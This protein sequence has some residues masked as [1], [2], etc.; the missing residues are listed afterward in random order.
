M[1]DDPR[2]LERRNEALRAFVQEHGITATHVAERQYFDAGWD[3]GK[4]E[5]ADFI[6]KLTNHEHDLS[7]TADGWWVCN[8]CPYQTKSNLT[9]RAGRA[10]EQLEQLAEQNDGLA[11][12]IKLGGN[13]QRRLEGELEQLREA[14]KKS[15]AR[16]NEIKGTD[17][18]ITQAAILSNVRMV[19]EAALQHSAPSSPTQ[20][21]VNKQLLEWTTEA[22]QRETDAVKALRSLLTDVDSLDKSGAFKRLRGRTEALSIL[23]RYDS[24]PAPSPDNL[25][26]RPHEFDGMTVG[27]PCERCARPWTDDIHVASPDQ[28]GK[29]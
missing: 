24:A 6:E 26:M 27:Q 7:P 9:E 1:T 13:E 5:A 2:G 18:R 22:E 21:D 10:E 25:E 23:A 3:A 29:P 8:S 17:N 16:L 12:A 28:E 4:R 20:G 15:L 19:I 14:L 11:L